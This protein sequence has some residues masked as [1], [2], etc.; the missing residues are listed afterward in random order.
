M[1]QTI[2]AN[3][4]VGE[5]ETKLGNF[6][7]QAYT[8]LPAFESGFVSA[9]ER[10]TT[11]M[12][13]CQTTPSSFGPASPILAELNTLSELIRAERARLLE[14]DRQFEEWKAHLAGKYSEEEAAAWLE[15]NMPEAYEMMMTAKNKLEKI[16]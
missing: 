10:Y 14:L 1:S 4:T 12:A 6:L 9:M 7:R 16:A 5:G 8:R 11:W 2:E 3:Q 13:G 15:K